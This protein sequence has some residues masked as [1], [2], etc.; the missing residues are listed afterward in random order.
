MTVDHLRKDTPNRPDI[1]R[2]AICART[3][4]H[5]GRSIP[6]SYDLGVSQR[7]SFRPREYTYFVGEGVHWNAEGPGQ[8]KV[9]N[10]ELAFS[11]DEELFQ[12]LL[13][14]STR[15]EEHLIGDARS[16]A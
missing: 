12:L 2:G 11:I 3:H 16:V 14:E 6:K 4:E 15:R 1:D 8:T 9:T 5:I 10:L 13:K 7:G